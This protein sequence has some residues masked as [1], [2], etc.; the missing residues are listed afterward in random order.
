MRVRHQRDPELRRERLHRSLERRSLVAR[1]REVR[2]LA[3][4]IQAIEI[5]VRRGTTHGDARMGGV[6]GRADQP[7]LLGTH[8]GEQDAAPRFL[9]HPAERPRELEQY[10]AASS[11]VHSSVV[12]PVLPLADLL[13][14]DMVPV[15][16]IQD[17]F[18]AE[19]GIA[20]RELG[21]HIAALDRDDRAAQVS[22]DAQT[23]RHRL[24]V[25]AVCHLQQFIKRLAAERIRG[26]DHAPGRIGAQP[27]GHRQAHRALL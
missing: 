2:C 8:E 4:R 26:T 22:A 14:T 18:L 13:H 10:R 19:G 12:D 9:R 23:Q 17:G 20:T 25:R 11:V 7:A 3:E 24:E 16:G 15:G 6:V 21:Q 27:A 5:E 1:Q